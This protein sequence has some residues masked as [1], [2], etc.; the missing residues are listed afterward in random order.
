MTIP[1]NQARDVTAESIKQKLESMGMGSA[2]MDIYICIYP[3]DGNGG[4]LMCYPYN[5]GY[6]S[7]CS[8]ILELLPGMTFV[9]SHAEDVYKIAPEHIADS[10]EMYLQWSEEGGA[11]C[12]LKV[13][14][15]GC[16][17]TVIATHNFTTENDIYKTNENDGAFCE[18]TKLQFRTAKYKEYSE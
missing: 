12:G 10:Y 16:N 7:T 17:G 14:R 1:K 11:P 6:N 15:G 2:S 8:D 9:S 4:R 13:P 3:I 5:T 18:Y